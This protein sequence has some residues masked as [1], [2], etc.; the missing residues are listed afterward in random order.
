MVG[1]AIEAPLTEAR[2]TFPRP[3]LTMSALGITFTGPQP[4]SARAATVTAVM[5]G[6]LF[7]TS[8]HAGKAHEHGAGKLNLVQDSAAYTLELELPLDTLVGFE[9]APRTAAERQAAQAA[10]ARLRDPAALFRTQP[11]SAGCTISAADIAA[12]LLEASAAPPSQNAQAKAATQASAKPA[13]SG[14]Q[15]ADAHAD[16]AATYT[17]QCPP[18]AAPQRLEVMLFEAFPRL[19]RLEVQTAL[20]GGQGRVKL[21]PGSRMIDL[22]R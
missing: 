18:Q 14:T 7:T 8:A 15:V 9:R 3:G 21:S 13:P 22:R 10:L 20:A 6:L 1:I 11:A 2:T 19:K 5:A 12:P 17:L 4:T 16:A